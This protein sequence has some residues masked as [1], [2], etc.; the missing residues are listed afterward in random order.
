MNDTKLFAY[1]LYQFSSIS[2]STNHQNNPPLMTL[3]L[4][5][6]ITLPENP[7]LIETL[8]N[9]RFSVFRTGKSFSRV[10]VDMAIEQTINTETKETVKKHNGLCRYCFCHQQ[11]SCYKLH[12]KSVCNFFNRDR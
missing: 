2:F 10:G 9:E 5:E 7:I 12:E 3:Y 8:H 1:V 4:L 11:V 6:L